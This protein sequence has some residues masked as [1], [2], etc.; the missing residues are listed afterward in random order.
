VS[1]KGAKESYIK[2]VRKH[3]DASAWPGIPLEM[4]VVLTSTKRIVTIFKV[5]DLRINP[6][7]LRPGLEVFC[8]D[9]KQ[10]IQRVVIKNISGDAE[11]VWV[12]DGMSEWKLF[13]DLILYT[14]I[15]MKPTVVLLENL[16]MYVPYSTAQHVW[17]SEKLA[18]GD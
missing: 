1:I 15:P 8:L 4:L 18:R 9:R 16:D 7:A 11:W 17:K 3:R 5:Y 2:F 10:D 12:T 14:P 6:P 13:S